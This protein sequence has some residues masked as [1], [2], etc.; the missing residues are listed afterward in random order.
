MYMWVRMWI[1]YIILIFTPAEDVFFVRKVKNSN[2]FGDKMTESGKLLKMEVDY[3]DTV[4][5]S[6]PELQEMAKVRDFQR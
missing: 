6:L 2:W 5:K 3:S 1:Y 4:D